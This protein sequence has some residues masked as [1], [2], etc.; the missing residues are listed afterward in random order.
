MRK[1]NRTEIISL[2]I[3]VGLIT[4]PLW[5]KILWK[6]MLALANFSDQTKVDWFLLTITLFFLI[7]LIKYWKG[8]ILFCK[9]KKQKDL[10]KKKKEYL[11]VSIVLTFIFIF[12]LMLTI[13]SQ[14]VLLTKL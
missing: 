6:P 14:I 1:F 3:A 10:I 5:K 4:R 2:I 13:M 12:I 8:Y 11:I 7:F 9:N